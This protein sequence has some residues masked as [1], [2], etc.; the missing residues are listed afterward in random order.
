M[1]EIDGSRFSGSGTIVRQAVALSG[2]TG[3]DVHIVNARSARPGPGLRAQHTWVVE[4]IRRLV[5]GTTV[6][7]CVG[8]QDLIFRPG[9]PR[10]RPEYVWD[11]GSAGSTAL[12]ALAVLPVL[13]FAPSPVKVVLR[14]GLFQDA[15]PSFHHLRHVVLPMLRRMGVDADL[16]MRRPGFVPE[17]KGILHLK[18][19]PMM[20]PMGPLVADEPGAVERVWGVALSSHLEKQNVSVRMA[21][22]AGDVLAA[23]GHK[24]SFELIHDK[25]A[26]QPGA[27][28]AAFADL[29]SGTRLGADRAGAPRRRAEAVGLYVARELLAD[30]RTGATVDR[31]AADQIMT[32]AALAEGESSFVVPEISDHLEACAWL[33]REF[34]GAEVRM[35]G[36]RVT[37][38]GVGIRPQRLR[39]GRT[40]AAAS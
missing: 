22:K 21:R 16:E 32:F 13:A 2:L 19:G 28:L 40:Q 27:A 1:L 26:V 25:T 36:Q 10:F 37:V 7:N 9:L 14:G 29:G 24:A 17:G 12:L 33:V 15:A 34:L 5:D 6:G 4:A 38:K 18:A 39:S 20:G 30:L 8:S 35:R 11:I 3:L 31:H 23:A